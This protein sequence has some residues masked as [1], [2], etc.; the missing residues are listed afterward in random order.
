MYIVRANVLYM[1]LRYKFYDKPRTPISSISSV[2]YNS[3]SKETSITE[4]CR[5]LTKILPSNC[6]FFAHY[7][8]DESIF[9]D[10][11]FHLEV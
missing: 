11:F 7:K 1:Y 2:P 3:R 8:L 6:T 9:S 5:V 4:N 10:E